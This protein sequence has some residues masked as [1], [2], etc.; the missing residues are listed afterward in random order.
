MSGIIYD[1]LSSNHLFSNRY[2]RSNVSK[3]LLRLI[4]LIIKFKSKNKTALNHVRKTE[5]YREQ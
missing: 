4:E 1:L 5:F 3:K 2:Y